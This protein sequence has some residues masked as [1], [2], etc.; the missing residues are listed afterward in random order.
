MICQYCRC[1]FCWDE[2]DEGGGPKLYCSRVC[3]RKATRRRQRARQGPTPPRWWIESNLAACAGQG[4]QQYP[5]SEWAEAGAAAVFSRTGQP[6]RAYHC[7]G[8][9]HW[10]LTSLR[11][12]SSLGDKND[13]PELP[14]V[15]DCRHVPPGLFGLLPR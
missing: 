11:P 12:H 1:V 6:L 8:T 7:P 9:G 13:L 3:T 5:N 4:K 10:H 15:D 2:A 14:A